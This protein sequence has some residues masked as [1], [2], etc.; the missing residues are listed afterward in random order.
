L[1]A[2]PAVSGG[3]EYVLTVLNVDGKSAEWSEAFTYVVPDGAPPVVESIEL[4][5]GYNDTP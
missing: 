3:G 5:V 1:A 2:T 4:S